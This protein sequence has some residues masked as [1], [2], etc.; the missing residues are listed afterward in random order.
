[1]KIKKVTDEEFT[2]RGNILQIK[3]R[4]KKVENKV[5]CITSDKQLLGAHVFIS[6]KRTTKTIEVNKHDNEAKGI[7]NGSVTDFISLNTQ[8]NE[9]SD[10]SVDW[11]PF[12]E[13]WL[14]LFRLLTKRS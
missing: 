8:G 2:P 13:F 12:R 11:P 4:H 10:R 1:M 3:T 14:P 7:K 6:H 9:I 5:K